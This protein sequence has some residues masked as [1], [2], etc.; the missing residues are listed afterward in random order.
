MD[1]MQTVLWNIEVAFCPHGG[2][3]TDCPLLCTFHVRTNSKEL[4]CINKGVDPGGLST[5]KPKLKYFFN[6]KRFK[7]HDFCDCSSLTCSSDNDVE[8]TLTAESETMQMAMQKPYRG[9][10]ELN[11]WSS[12]C[13]KGLS[14]YCW[15][16]VL[17]MKWMF[18]AMLLSLFVKCMALHC[19]AV[20]SASQQCLQQ[21]PVLKLD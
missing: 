20:F 6:I 15:F 21:Q 16:N 11:A 17:H 18:K 8:V 9:F 2:L 14:T 4:H 12:R 1:V 19:G 7:I 13:W 5:K 10:T 3:R